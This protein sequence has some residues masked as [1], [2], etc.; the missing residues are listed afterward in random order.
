MQGKS[1]EE[2]QDSCHEALNSPLL[3]EISRVLRPAGF[4]GRDFEAALEE[5]AQWKRP[6]P[7]WDDMR[8]AC[9]RA[10]LPREGAGLQRYVL[11]TAGLKYLKQVAG[12]RVASSVKALLYDE[13]CFVARGEKRW[14]SVLDLAHTSFPATCRIL[15]LQRFPAG[16]TH[17]EV[18]GFPKS[19]FRA[20]PPRELPRAGAFLLFRMRGLSPFFVCHMA[21]RWT[22]PV[23]LREEEDVKSCY[24]MAASMMLQPE[25]RG[26]MS[27]SWLNDPNI[28]AYSPHLAWR[29][30]KLRYGAMLTTI[31]AAPP[32][33]GFLDGSPA[34]KQKH[35]EDN[36]TPKVGVLLW[37]RGEMLSWA[38]GQTSFES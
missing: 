22:Q 4:T 27:S 2:A 15:T 30:N 32:D 33:S 21:T 37:P 7:R 29:L 10:E 25:V 19:W 12:L 11:L 18:S 20:M 3:N 5:T 17:W 9:E 16:Q 36:W 34:R 8:Q 13:F 35:D 14:I 26:Y 6:S 24:R 38:R 28:A 31:G 23:I 1:F